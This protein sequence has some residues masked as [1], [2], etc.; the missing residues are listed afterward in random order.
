MTTINSCNNYD[1][2]TGVFF[3]YACVFRYDEKT[4]FSSKVSFSLHS[5]DL[6]W[7]IATMHILIPTTWPDFVPVTHVEG[8]GLNWFLLAG[9]R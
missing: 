5:E 3:C 6:S 2:T 7:P 8:G 1:S 4:F 9:L